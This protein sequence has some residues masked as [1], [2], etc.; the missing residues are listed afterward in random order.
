[1]ANL[2]ITM[3]LEHY[4]RH[5]PFFDGSVTIEG[6]D[7]TVLHVA[8]SAAGRHG[9]RRHER[10]L[11]GE[12]D[13]AELSLSSYLMARDRGLPFTAIP[14]FP[15]RLFSQSRIYVNAASGITRPGDLVGRR[16]GLNSYQTTLSVLAKGDLAHEYGVPWKEITWV[17]A[18]DEAVPFTPPPDV[19]LERV[20]AGGRLDEM[21]LSGAL[22]AVALPHPPRS[23]QDAGPRVR[24]LFT[25]ARA[26]EAAYFRRNGYWPIMH[27][28]AFKEALVH[29]HPWLPGAVFA[30]FERAKALSREYYADPN[31][32][33]LAWARYYEEEEAE[34][35]APDPWPFGLAANR[36][37]LARFV[38][39]SYEQGLI[40]QRM[41][42][43]SLFVEV[44]TG[45]A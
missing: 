23:I 42:P 5:V 43:E 20:P 17:L 40:G 12:F 13:V 22:D 29:A 24:R 6:V 44:A 28:M 14:V 1:M 35:L 45:S 27:V 26:E 34:R 18:S 41:A 31:W 39:Y 9:S 25:D 4:D 15:R 21:L 36:A 37:N 30:A 2:P 11:A 32:S 10:M 19:R 3:A 38:E 7:L 16:V 33:R 8:Q